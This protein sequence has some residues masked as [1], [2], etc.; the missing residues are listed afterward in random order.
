M[1]Y[2][3]N[4]IVNEDKSGI[5][6]AELKRIAM[7]KEHH[8]PAKIVTRDFSLTF[9]DVI[10][11]VGLQDSDVINL[12]DFFGESTDFAGQPCGVTDLHI[13]SNLELLVN[14][15]DP[16]GYMV[17][18]AQRIIQR[19][20]MRAPD[21]KKVEVIRTYDAYGHLAKAEWYDTRG[22]RA[23]EQFFDADGNLLAEQVYN[24]DG[25]L[26]YQTFHQRSP[27]SNQKIVN[28]LYRIIDWHGHDYSFNGQKE[29]TRFFYDELNK[30]DQQAVFIVDRTMELAWPALNMHTP[31]VK[32]MHLHSAHLNNHQD[33]MHSSLNFNY[34]YALNNLDKWDGVIMPT[35]RQE[36]DFQQRYGTQTPTYVIP[37]G[38]VPDEQFDKKPVPWDERTKGLVIMVARLSPEKQQDQ[39]IK[40]FKQ[41]VAKLPNARLEFWGYAY[42]HEDKRLQKLVNDEHMEKYVAFKNYTRDIGKVYDQ[43]QLSVLSSRTEGFS[44]ALLESQ[45]HGVPMLA[46]DVPYGPQEII[47][48]G[49]D[50][51]LVKLNDVDAL[52]AKMIALLSDQQKAAAFSKHAYENAKK[53]KATAIWKDWL[54]L[55][56]DAQDKVA[57]E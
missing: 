38:V 49:E 43:A 2:F 26:F 40:A 53:F 23:L 19:I 46:Y 44:L 12:F 6:H 7:F 1:Y 9:H 37:V 33:V 29:L 35:A 24:P 47:H 11:H 5:E 20:G 27:F 28:T 39:V 55:M 4:T 52:A 31:V 50:G 13:S 17:R 14:D 56:H 45:A 30:Q 36:A 48:N 16:N 22:F 54:K 3:L 51:Y 25:K 42:E 32:Y 41:V 34:E 18:N 10:H 15:Q 57:K 21:Y 8:V